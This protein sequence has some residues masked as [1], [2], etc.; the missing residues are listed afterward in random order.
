MWI[1]SESEVELKNAIL[2]A[3]SEPHPAYVAAAS[4]DQEPEERHLWHVA[5]SSITM[6]N[7]TN[8][9]SLYAA[10]LNVASGFWANTMPLLPDGA[11]STTIGEQ[12]EK[13]ARIHPR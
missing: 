13:V 1:S 12:L 7:A 9:G 3:L 4:R 6:T 11:V 10:D 5:T 2:R 8:S